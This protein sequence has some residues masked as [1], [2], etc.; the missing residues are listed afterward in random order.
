MQRIL[1]YKLKTKVSLWPK[2]GHDF[3]GEAREVF[4]GEV[5]QRLK[6]HLMYERLHVF[7]RFLPVKLNDFILQLIMYPS[8][9]CL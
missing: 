1:V 5:P 3:V 2:A 4:G 9:G 8:I 7:P 6:F